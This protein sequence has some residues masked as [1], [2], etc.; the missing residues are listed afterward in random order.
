MKKIVVTGGSG[1]IGTNLVNFLLNKKCIVFN[2]DKLSTESV[3]EKNKKISNL[4]KYFFYKI[5][6]CNKKKIFKALKKIQPNFIIHLA[7][8][9]HV[10]RSIDDPE[11]FIKNNI[12]ATTTLYNVVNELNLKKTKIIHVST[13]EVFGSKKNGLSNENDTFQP[14]SPYSSSKASSDLIAKSFFYTF[15]LSI[16][17][18]NICNN[19]GPYQFSE[20]FIPKII[21]N[22]LNKKKIP[23]YGNGRNIREWIYVEDCCNA[24]YQCILRSKPGFNYNIG[25]NIRLNNI[26]L[27]KKIIRIL[28]KF[29]NKKLILNK[30]I[31]YVKDRPGHDFRYALN[32]RYFKKN[33]GWECKTNLEKGL[34]KTID[35]YIKNKSF[36]SSCKKKYNGKRQGII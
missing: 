19:Y 18:I 1:F 33:I 11:K 22:I 17:I 5:D 25:S 20:K 14:T 12:M 36:I 15:N 9:T 28:R 16:V 29:Y 3:S 30:I 13:D 21:I 31:D 10:D 26:Y 8:E 34:L 4:K 7:A 35:W 6:L 2:I 23:V 24:I 32:S 27:I